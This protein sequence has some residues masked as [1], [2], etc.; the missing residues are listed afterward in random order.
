[1]VVNQHRVPRRSPDFS[2]SENVPLNRTSLSNLSVNLYSTLPKSLTSREL[3]VRA[4]FEE[5]AVQRQRS[6]VVRTKS[7]TE[8]SRIRS[9][10]E[11][12]IPSPLQKIVRAAKPRDR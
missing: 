7:V 12:P 6:D 1:L 4:K 5:P 11:F 10:A 8:L 9:L 3:L 2:T